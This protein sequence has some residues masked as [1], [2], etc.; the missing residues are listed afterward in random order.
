M[1]TVTSKFGMV[2]VTCPCIYEIYRSF[3]QASFNTLD[4]PGSGFYTFHREILAKREA[5]KCEFLAKQTE[6]FAKKGERL[7][8]V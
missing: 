2:C 7:A 3:M 5:L 4:P 8:K 6:K 1:V